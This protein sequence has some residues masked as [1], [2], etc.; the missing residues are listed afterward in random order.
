MH[1]FDIILYVCRHESL[2]IVSQE[3]FL[4]NGVNCIMHVTRALHVGVSVVGFARQNQRAS[5]DSNNATQHVLKT[6]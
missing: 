2:A 1:G 6:N 4:S 5:S 3:K